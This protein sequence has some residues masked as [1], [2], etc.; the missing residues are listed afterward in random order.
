MRPEI[1][2]KPKLITIFQ[3]LRDKNKN[4][5][6]NNTAISANSDMNFVNKPKNGPDEIAE[7]A[8][9]LKNLGIFFIFSN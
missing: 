5:K 6:A 9:R 2:T 1:A 4:L 7:I 3:N 8:W